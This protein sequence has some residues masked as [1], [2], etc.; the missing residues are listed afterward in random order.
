[1]K[2]S[3]VP[4]SREARGQDNPAGPG[5]DQGP[6]KR[7]DIPPVQNQV[8]RRNLPSSPAAPVRETP[9]RVSESSSSE[10]DESQ[11]DLNL[12]YGAGHVVNLF[13]PVTACM[14]AVVASIQTVSTYTTKDSKN[15]AYLIYTPFHPTDEDSTGT[16]L[17]QSLANSMIMISVIA[18]MTFFLV[19]L[20]KYRCMKV[21]HVW[22]FLSSLMLMF[23]FGYMYLRE[24]LKAYNVALDWITL[25]ITMWNFGVVGI[26]CIH[27]KGPL[28]LQQCYLISCSALM[29]LVFIKYLPDWTT[30]FILAVLSIYDLLAVLCPYG[31]L[32]ILVET[33]HERDDELFPALIYSSG[34]GIVVP[35]IQT[36][37]GSVVAPLLGTGMA[38]QTENQTEVPQVQ[39]NQP[40]RQQRQNNSNSSQTESRRTQ[41]EQN[42]E[43]REGVKLGLGD[44]IF[45]SVLVGKAS[46]SGDW[47]VTLAC[48]VAIL[49]GL[50][51]TLILL[52][53]WQKALP[54]LPISITLGLIFYF[55]TYYVITPFMEMCIVQQVFL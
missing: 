39:V 42:N 14:I 4:K 35:I 16:I 21:I 7:T 15:E 50:G 19:M 5:A 55:A 46:T 6:A 2:E 12:K 20:Y 34:S 38:N 11:Q 49:V 27:W 26:V 53:F 29:A 23:M 52:A 18:V 1:M 22:L 45:Y 10:N 54:A 30:W 36:T 17:W 28:F 37:T 33:A 48:V 47:N 51:A 43:R 44:F 8:S 24:V 13:I 9:R 31:P 25:A 40:R 3:F 32:R 41:S